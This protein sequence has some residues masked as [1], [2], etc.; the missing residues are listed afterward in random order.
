MIRFSKNRKQKL[1]N[2]YYSLLGTRF[3]IEKI[4]YIACNVCCNYYYIQANTAQYN[5]TLSLADPSSLLELI[6]SKN[7]KPMY[8]YVFIFLMINI[9]FLFTGY[10]ITTPDKILLKYSQHQT[11]LFLN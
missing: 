6:S 9:Y 7:N 8:V 3:N 5:K 1:P 10:N 2:I 11:Q 4:I